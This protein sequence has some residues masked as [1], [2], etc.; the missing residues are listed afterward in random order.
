MQLFLFLND[1]AGRFWPLDQ[2]MRFF[3]VAAVPSLA[4]LFLAQLLVLPRSA[5]APS[6]ARIASVIA[7]SLLLAIFLVFGFEYFSQVL[8]LGVISPRPFMTRRV[9]LLLVEP[10]DNS[11]PCF[12][13]TVAAIFAVGMAFSSRKWGL[14]A[15]GVTVLLALARMYCGTNFLADVVVGALLGVGVT[16]LCGALFE[17]RL[18]VFE[19]KP[20]WQWG[21]S[22]GILALT[23]GG[24]YFSLASMPRFAAKLP[25]FWSSPATAAT[26]EIEE[27]Q[28]APQKA[29]KAARTALQEGEG[30]VD[31]HAEE[32]SAEE[33]A[34]S[35]RSH[36]FLP[37]V[38]KFLKGRLSPLARPFH[39]LDVEVA[40]VKAGNS[41]YRCAALRFEITPS[42]PNL[43]SD[44]AEVAARLVKAAFASDSQLENVD[45]T[46]ILRG[47]A[48]QIDGSDVRFAGDE[49]P[50]FTASIQR[51]KLVV[52]EPKWANDP[53]LDGGSWLRT[54]SL[55]YIN[56]KI[57]P[58]PTPVAA[59]PTPVATPLP[60]VTPVRPIV[61]PTPLRTLA[62]P[63]ATP[64]P[65]AVPKPIVPR[66]WPKA[67]PR[68]TR[69]LAPVVK[70]PAS[71]GVRV[72]P[73]VR[74]T[75]LPPQL[76]P[77]QP[78]KWSR[79]RYRKWNRTTSPS[80]RYSRRYKRFRRAR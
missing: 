27:T 76:T 34:L 63:T 35:K 40:P 70:K 4:T 42:R 17:I 66:V 49:V 54:R 79:S 19:F 39:L 58:L 26:P 43:R 33:L 29:T 64:R 28:A 41:P 20:A 15:G 9:N 10:Q 30:V 61:T 67:T 45:V 78:R 47:D 71:G 22:T 21:I 77:A 52:A 37:E 69:S 13:L 80:K 51:E 32:P 1:L 18:G 55:L 75:P 24:T 50:V 14:C 73:A 65:T 46:A 72:T 62:S 57:L 56:P 2:A 74:P 38:E 53:N 48:Q 7:F 25:V 36:L 11:F 59:V 60:T 23:L 12:E 5:E 68:P 8:N 3:Y 16:A 44:T 6:R 31:E